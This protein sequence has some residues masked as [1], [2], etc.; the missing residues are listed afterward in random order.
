[1]KSLAQY[2]EIEVL[3]AE[4]KKQFK[5]DARLA[6]IQWWKVEKPN[7]WMLKFLSI[8]LFVCGWFYALRCCPFFR[9]KG[10]WFFKKWEVT[11]NHVYGFSGTL[12][13]SDSIFFKL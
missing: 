10:H 9:D 3:R 1:M 12:R 5:S 4:H 2:K 11:G 7:T 13:S 6:V 8:D